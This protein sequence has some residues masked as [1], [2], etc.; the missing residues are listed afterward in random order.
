METKEQDI[1]DNLYILD[2]LDFDFKEMQK[3]P[4]P[5]LKGK[6]FGEQNFD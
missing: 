6:N 2:I 4:I 1:I 5:F 3:V